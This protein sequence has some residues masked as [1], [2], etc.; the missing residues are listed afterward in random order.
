MRGMS[1]DV[2]PGR[3]PASSRFRKGQSG[4]PKGRPRKPKPPPEGGSAFDVI[5]DRTLTVTQ[6]GVERA[7]TLDEA[8]QLQTYKDALAGNRSSRRTIL[9]MIEKREAWLARHRGTEEWRRVEVLTERGDPDNAD[10]VLLLLGIAC[11][12]PQRQDIGAN[13]EQL[14]LEP[15]AVQAA[16]SRR[17]GG[18]KLEQ[19][20]I[21]EVRR[22]TRDPHTLRW[23]RATP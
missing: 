14:L 17:R 13:R 2:G 6:G 19:K 18:S 11:H 23:P 8:L 10:G 20:D 12:D 5:I 3:P 7:L 15:W 22:C 21:D 1:G 9:K 16:L 4:N